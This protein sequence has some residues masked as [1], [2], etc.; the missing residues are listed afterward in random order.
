MDKVINLY[1]SE[2][3]GGNFISRYPAYNEAMNTFNAALPKD[4]DTAALELAV[5]NII[6]LTE[7]LAFTDGFKAGA[8][9]MC[10]VITLVTE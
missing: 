4:T 1:L 8:N 6:A 10:E 9:H 3:S 7:K 2:L 5:D